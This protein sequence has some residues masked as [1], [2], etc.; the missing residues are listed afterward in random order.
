MVGPPTHPASDKSLVRKLLRRER[1]EHH[2]ALPDAVRGLL[3]SQPPSPLKAVLENAATVGLYVAVGAEA[4]ALGYAKWLYERGVTLALPWFS[5]RESAMTFVEWQNPFDE[6][7]LIPGPLDI[8]QPANLH[9]E[10][11]PDLLIVPLLGFTANGQRLGQGG[12]HY[13]RWLEAHP[14]TTAIGLA[15]D[16]QLRD[17]LPVEAHDRPLAMIV[18]PTQVFCP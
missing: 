11:V 17:A 9:G 12:G 14:E 6:E 3:F 5:T 8:P 16:C 1:R 10:I 13:D 2:A 18:T 4:P 7:E 15:W